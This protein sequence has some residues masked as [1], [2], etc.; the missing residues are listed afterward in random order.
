MDHAACHVVYVDKRAYKERYEKR[1]GPVSPGPSTY[2]T[3]SAEGFELEA[4]EVQLNLHE[5]LSVFNGGEYFG[6]PI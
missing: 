1:G 5:I 4:K 6:P 2:V 3:E